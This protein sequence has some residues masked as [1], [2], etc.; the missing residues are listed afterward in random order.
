MGMSEYVR[1]LRARIGNELLLVPAVAV[2]L[3]DD[4]GRLLLGHRSDADR[5]AM[6][7]GAI[8]P[9]ETPVE[10]A[11]REAREETSLEIEITELRG[12]F[13]GRDFQATF[14]N[15]DR[16][17][18]TVVLFEGRIVRGAMRPD[19]EE[20]RELLFSSGEEVA[21][22][23]MRSSTRLLTTAALRRRPWKAENIAG[24]TGS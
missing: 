1:G 22:L 2:A 7:G 19:G 21:S 8:D 16:I 3:F 5:W 15:G 9:G 18:A 10:A 13:G 23:P 12:V 4:K 11:V 6:I 17:E 20:I 24:Q 14:E